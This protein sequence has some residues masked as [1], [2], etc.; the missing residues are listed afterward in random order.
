MPDRLRDSPMPP[1]QPPPHQPPDPA[2]DVTMHASG[3]SSSTPLAA[4]R[5][6]S[7][8]SAQ[9]PLCAC[10]GRPPQWP[11]PRPHE[12]RV[13]A[14][15][16]VAKSDA[17]AS[18]A[19]DGQ[20]RSP[21]ACALPQVR[22]EP[23]AYH[24]VKEEP[25]PAVPPP[26]PPVVP[27][28]ERVRGASPSCGPQQEPVELRVVAPLSVAQR[29]VSASVVPAANR[30]GPMMSTQLQRLSSA[31]NPPVSLY[32]SQERKPATATC[33][34]APPRPPDRLAPS[35]VLWEAPRPPPPWVTRVGAGW[36]AG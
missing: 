9:A 4:P 25:G 21:K 26:A 8:A 16:L 33:H 36:V 18:D 3:I 2:S 11:Q 34:G 6:P 1:P 12:H 5:L 20:R 14:P 22:K 19:S 32:T 27:V 17:R 15:L 10:D 23:V 7:H 28:P 35:E 13:D 29:D 30:Q 31:D 24:V